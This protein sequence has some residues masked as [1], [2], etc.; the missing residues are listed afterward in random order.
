LVAVGA[1]VIVGIGLS[2]GAEVTV[3][4]GLVD[5]VG[6][7]VADGLALATA[8]GVG[9]AEFG[10]AEGEGLVVAAP[11]AVTDTARA[12]DRINSFMSGTPSVRSEPTSVSTSLTIVFA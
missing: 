11:H 2:L 7:T 9:C 1:A 6:L 8:I 4:A 5:T 3:A 10:Y 12:R